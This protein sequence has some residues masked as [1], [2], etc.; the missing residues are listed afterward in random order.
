[1]ESL[2]EAVGG[3]FGFAIMVSVRMP[4]TRIRLRGVPVEHY[5][6]IGIISAVLRVCA[7]AYYIARYPLRAL[8]TFGE[9]A[10]IVVGVG[11]IG[12]FIIMPLMMKK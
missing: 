2:R 10:I 3:L 4:A 12:L 11:A 1:M 8:R 7:A 5:P 9:W 6:T